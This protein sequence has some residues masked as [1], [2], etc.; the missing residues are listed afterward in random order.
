MIIRAEGTN[1]NVAIRK[2]VRTAFGQPAEA[3]LVD[4]LRADGDSMISLVAVDHDQV[5]GHVLLSKMRAPFK[6]LA[7]APVS[8]APCWQRSGIGGALIR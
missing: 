2:V 3:V 8:V 1:D 6:A 5:V 4:Q 7:L